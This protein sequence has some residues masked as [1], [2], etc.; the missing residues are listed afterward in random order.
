MCMFCNRVTTKVELLHIFEKWHTAYHGT[1]TA[2]VRKI[3]DTG[4]LHVAGEGVAQQVFS[5]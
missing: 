5:H 4:D 1:H 3:L 2:A